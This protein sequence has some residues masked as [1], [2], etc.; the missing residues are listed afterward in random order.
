MK[1]IQIN[2]LTYYFLLIY[3]LCGFIKEGIIIFIIVFIH[4]LGHAFFANLFNFNIISITIYPFGGITKMKKDINTP[5]NED[6]LISIG[7]F[8]FQ[9]ILYLIFLIINLNGFISNKTF[10]IFNFYNKMILLFNLLPIIPL[11][12]SYI[13]ENIL[14]RIFPYKIVLFTNVILSIFCFIIFIY[15]NYS[16][17]LN[18]YIIISFLF[19]K[20]LENLKNKKNIFNKF[21]LERYLYSYN[22][23]KLENINSIDTSKIKKD[24]YSY[25]W[26][27]FCYVSEKD[28][29]NKKYNK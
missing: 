20:I 1:I 7:G 24:T 2:Y 27:E 11:D 21:L 13:S 29:L 22:F 26:K 12:G 14:S 4:E 10:E 18:N 9:F 15:Y 19:F 16:Y 28:I 3:F 17:N 23:K 8:I 5:L 6:L 25:F